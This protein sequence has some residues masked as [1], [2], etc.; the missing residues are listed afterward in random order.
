MNKHDHED[1]D[2]SAFVSRSFE[3]PTWK[4][5]SPTAWSSVAIEIDSSASSATPTNL[6]FF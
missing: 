1:Q 5:Q 3:T 6:F 2:E 4:S